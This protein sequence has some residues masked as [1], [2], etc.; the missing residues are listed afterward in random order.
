MT[1]LT[2]LDV[3]AEEL[4]VWVRAAPLPSGL[5]GVYDHDYR[6]IT[7][8]PGMGRPQRRSTLAHEL[9]HAYYGHRFTCPKQERVADIWSARVLLYP[10]QVFEEARFSRDIRE[11]APELGVM[12]WVVEVFVESSSGSHIEKMLAAASAVN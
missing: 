12:P 8:K 4:G 10:L 9:G 6:L 1:C 2:P 3:I 5:W 7:L 11:L